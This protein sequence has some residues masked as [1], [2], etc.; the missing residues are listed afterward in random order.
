MIQLNKNLIYLLINL[1]SASLMDF[2]GIVRGSRLPIEI[3]EDY[4]PRNV[5]GMTP[6]T[7]RTDSLKSKTF[8]NRPI[9]LLTV[10]FVRSFEVNKFEQVQSITLFADNEDYWHFVC[11][12]CLDDVKTVHAI[13]G[14]LI[15]VN[16]QPDGF[17]N[18]AL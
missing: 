12:I 16:K 10:Q 11:I 4:E 9:Q 17:N 18:V 6:W 5:K 15:C 8:N 13:T 1:F 14:M 3:S 2:S 7:N